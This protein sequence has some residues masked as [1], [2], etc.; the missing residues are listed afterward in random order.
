MSLQDIR[1]AWR[2]LTK[3]PGFTALAVLCLALGIGTNTT[4][5]SVVD[6]VLLSPRGFAEPERLVAIE[7]RH[8]KSGVEETEPSYQNFRDWQEQST[9]FS[10][11]AAQG[12]RSLT[13]SDGD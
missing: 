12:W 13:L 4:I 1:Y 10:D 2:S 6:G 11:M 9:V 8:L 7:E 5:F 3:T